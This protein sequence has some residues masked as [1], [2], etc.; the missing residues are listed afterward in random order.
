MHDGKGIL[1]D[2]EF[3]YVILGY[4]VINNLDVLQCCVEKYD[5]VPRDAVYICVEGHIA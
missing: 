5:Q 2:Y 4:S 1:S 3:R